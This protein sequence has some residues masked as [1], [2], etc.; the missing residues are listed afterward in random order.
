MSEI[1]Q[2]IADVQ[3]VAEAIPQDPNWM[4]IGI[5]LGIMGILAIVFMLPS[6]SQP[7][8]DA[9]DDRAE[10]K[11]LTGEKKAELPGEE[12]SGEKKDKL[13]LAEIKKEKRANVSEDMSKEE[14]RELRRERR[15]MTQTEKAVSEREAADESSAKAEAPDA[16]A[17]EGS[18]SD[19]SEV[20][21]NAAVKA[22]EEAARRA[23]EEAE[24][25][26]KALKEAEEAARKAREEAEAAE[27]K[28]KDIERMIEEDIVS[29][30]G[31]DSQD[32]FSSLFGDSGSSLNF[33]EVSQKEE[34]P[35]EGTVFPTLGS[36][37]I[38]LEQ[39][40]KAADEAE[41]AVDPFEELTKRM[42]AKAEKKTLK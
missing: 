24:A 14:L 17:N 7:E 16:H 4:L 35:V 5:I 36:A 38:P 31:S 33:D 2:A 6:K 3:Q 41:E 11:S 34:K 8:L 13:S 27:R 42:A 28:A 20:S 15:A 39:L 30:A 37:L 25:A 10:G 12:L 32:V 22:A 18:K 26:S 9:E 40:S 23:A 1:I 29:D 19:A 21:E